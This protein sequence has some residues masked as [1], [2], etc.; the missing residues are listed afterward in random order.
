MKLITAKNGVKYFR[1][2]ILSCKNAFATR[3]G[4][5][6]VLPHTAELNLAFGRGDSEVVVCNNLSVF[7]D[8]VGFEP[9]SVISVPQIHSANVV[10]VDSSHRGMGY[11]K[12]AP[13]ECDGYVTTDKNVILGVKTA[14]CVPILL[15]AKDENGEVI[16]IAALHAGWRGT[17]NAIAREGVK[18]LAD[19]GAD[20]KRIFA[21]I[22]PHICKDRFEVG[23]EC[24]NEFVRLL[25][26]DI[27]ELIEQRGDKY[28]PD[29][30]AINR[31]ILCERGVLPENIDTSDACTYC[32]PSLFYSHRRMNGVR[33]T[34]LSIIGF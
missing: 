20:P 23:E 11:Y 29:L 24:K 4:G 7:A 17:A 2:D 1:S 6:S 27:L 31:K 19:L 10:R 3:I 13:F 18:A 16:A 34:H 21:A 22:G 26:E 28:F 33:G 32:D 12:R 5:V 8:A 9:R 25:G 30:G 14:D 15:S